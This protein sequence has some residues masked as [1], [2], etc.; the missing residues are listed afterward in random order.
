MSSDR[1]STK[2]RSRRCTERNLDCASTGTTTDRGPFFGQFVTY[3]EYVSK[4]KPELFNQPGAPG[5][6]EGGAAAAVSAGD[7]DTKMLRELY[8]GNVPPGFSEAQLQ[9]FFNEQMNARHLSTK[10]GSAC[11]QTRISQV[12]YIAS[13]CSLECSLITTWQLDCRV[14]HLLNFGPL[15]KQIWR[16]H[17]STTAILQ[18]PNCVSG[19]PKNMKTR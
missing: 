7:P 12:H 6:P 16:W 18:V 14:L 13:Y 9:Q 11:I 15:R 17:T 5:L 19:G 8:I 3:G 10:P 2:A 4:N 1:P